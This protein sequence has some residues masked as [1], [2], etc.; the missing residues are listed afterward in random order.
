MQYLLTEEEYAALVPRKDLE[1]AERRIEEIC[2]EIAIST[3][4]HCHEKPAIWSMR[5]TLYCDD[6]VAYNY[7]PSV[8]NLSK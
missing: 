2:H 4:G 5:H 8:K 3:Q 6:C 7:C 1:R